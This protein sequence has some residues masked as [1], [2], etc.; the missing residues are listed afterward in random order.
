MRTPNLTAAEATNRRPG[1]FAYRTLA[2][3]GLLLSSLACGQS[4]PAAGQPDAAAANRDVGESASGGKS[5]AG[6][7]GGGGGANGGGSGSGGFTG[8]GGQGGGNDGGEVGGGGSPG[9]GGGA[10]G[11]G[12]T[13]GIPAG[14]AGGQ[15]G[16]GGSQNGGTGGGATGGM[17]GTG[18]AGGTGGS[19]TGGS[20]TGG[21][22]TGGTATGGAGTGG[23]GTGGSGTGGTG[24][25]G[26][27]GAG[28]RDGGVPDSNEPPSDP[29]GP[30]LDECFSDLR[31]LVGRWQIVSK[32]SL[33]GNSEARVALE[34]D[35]F[36][37]SGTVAW[38]A[39]RVGFVTPRA[40]AC[41]KNETALRGAYKTSHHN[42]SDVLTVVAEGRAWELKPP[43]ADPARAAAVLTPSGLPP[44]TLSQTTC[45]S[46]AGPCKSGGPCR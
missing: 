36:G 32:R 33:D 37:T 23:A 8:M 44:A 34:V 14:G 4:T 3:V 16:M 11:G 35:G 29:G 10:A 45:R 38:R 18:G 43:D 21:T 19:G 30:T 28:G 17:P 31:A 26:T 22:G 7:G 5:T 42:C 40:R 13:A 9:A 24:G 25:S 1:S 39:I 27:G 2:V 20:G 41:V 15:A 12:G 46:N 6:A